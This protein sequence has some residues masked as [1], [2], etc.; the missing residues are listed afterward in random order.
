MSLG[1]DLWQYLDVILYYKRGKMNKDEYIARYGEGA[2]EKKLAQGRARYKAHREEE[3]ARSKRYKE[4]HKEEE[5]Y[6]EKVK[7]R[8]KKYNEEHHD[9]VK[10]NVQESGRKGGRRYAKHLK[11]NRTGLQ[12]ARNRIRSN[13]RTQYKPYKEII[14]PDSQIH[15]EWVPKTADYRGVAL[16]ETDQHMH[17]IV[18]VIEILAGNITCLTEEQITKR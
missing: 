10:A 3:N 14:A 12:G 15:H 6:R 5:E 7:A 2:Y 9:K 16:V 18:D 11:D 4:A 8:T 13:H 1:R 17:G